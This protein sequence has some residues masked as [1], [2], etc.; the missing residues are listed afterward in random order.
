MVLQK[1]FVIYERGIF[2]NLP[3]GFGMAVQELIEVRQFLASSVV[4]LESWFILSGRRLRVY[5]RAK[6]QKTRQS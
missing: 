6:A 3:G 5:G 1:I 2:A 4:A